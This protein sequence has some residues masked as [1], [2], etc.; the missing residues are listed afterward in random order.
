MENDYFAV[1]Q[2]GLVVSY[3]VKRPD[4]HDSLAVRRKLADLFK[5][6][7][8]PKK[9]KLDM[10]NWWALPKH[11]YCFS[12]Q[13]PLGNSSMAMD[14]IVKGGFVSGVV[15]G[16]MASCEEAQID[17]SFAQRFPPLK[18]DQKGGGC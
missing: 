5:T 11:G 15:V 7:Y 14:I 18:K 8:M 3:K 9:S 16:P 2:N 17:R 10:D 13:P 4:L 1:S 12:A 6:A